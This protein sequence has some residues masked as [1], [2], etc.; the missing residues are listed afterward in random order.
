MTYIIDQSFLKCIVDVAGAFPASRRCVVFRSVESKVAK[1][2]RVSWQ[3][4]VMVEDFSGIFLRFA[5]ATSPQTVVRPPMADTVLVHFC[6]LAEVVS[7][8]YLFFKRMHNIQL[9]MSC[10]GTCT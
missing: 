5:W 9:A 6:G 4:H 3:L 8:V 1:L 10:F 7:F 2:V